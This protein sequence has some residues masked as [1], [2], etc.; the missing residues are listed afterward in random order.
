MFYINLLFLAPPADIGRPERALTRAFKGRKVSHVRSDFPTA[1]ASRK[2]QP[3][4]APQAGQA[5][6]RRDAK[7]HTRRQA[8]RRAVRARPTARVFKLAGAEGPNRLPDDRRQAV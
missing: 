7:S 3:R 5:N 2:A 4:L 1:T 8:G 6:A